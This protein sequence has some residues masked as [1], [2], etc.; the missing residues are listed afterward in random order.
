MSTYLDKLNLRPQERRLVVG[1]GVVIFIVLNVL[2]VWPHFGDWSL[3]RADLDK[4]R[5]DLFK[6]EK[7][8]AQAKGPNGYEAQLRKLEGEGEVVVADEQEIQLFRTVQSKVAANKVSVSDYGKVTQT[9]G[10]QNTNEFFEE[11]S[12]PITVNTG[13]KEL[14]DFLLDVGSGS[15]MIRVRDLD[16]K[17]ADQ[18]RY[19]LQGRVTLSANYQKKPAVKPAA[20]PTTPPTKP[21]A[22]AAAKPPTPSAAKAPVSPPGKTNPAAKISPSTVKKI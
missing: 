22:T 3:V 4:A 8:I 5:N 12:I 14:V 18:N 16:L 20:K 1:I 6:Y 9:S 17:P 11:Q 19:K 10:G 15:S 21:T 7:K 2:M 13:E